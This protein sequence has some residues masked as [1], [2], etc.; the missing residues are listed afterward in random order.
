MCLAIPAKV[1][2]TYDHEA[3]V[4]ILGLKRRADISLLEDVSVGDF[5]LLHAGFGIEKLDPEAAAETLELH[6]QIAALA[7]EETR[8]L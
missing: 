3:L 8:T 5:I 4:D 2:E 6:R 1:L 7:E